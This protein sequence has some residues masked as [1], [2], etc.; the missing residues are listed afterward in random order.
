M[1]SMEA[2]IVMTVHQFTGDVVINTRGGS[3]SL[4]VLD[5]EAVAREI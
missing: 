5:F 3:L 1:G 4:S 2:D